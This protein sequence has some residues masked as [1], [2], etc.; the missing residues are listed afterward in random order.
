M[1]TVCWSLVIIF[2]TSLHTTGGV[3]E[4]YVALGGRFETSLA[5]DEGN[6]SPEG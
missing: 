5:G 4:V 1:A 6:N 3:A 2:H